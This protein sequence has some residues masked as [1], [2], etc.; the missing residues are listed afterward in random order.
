MDINGKMSESTK[1]LDLFSRYPRFTMMVVNNHCT[2]VSIMK[3]MA[4]TAIMF[5]NHYQ[6]LY[7]MLHRWLESMIDQWLLTIVDDYY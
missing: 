2:Y 6:W 3:P 5:I 4:I 7:D 1:K